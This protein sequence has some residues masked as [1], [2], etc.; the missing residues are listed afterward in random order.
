LADMAHNFP[1]VEGLR[2]AQ[3][4]FESVK[5][6]EDVERLFLKGA[7]LSPNT[8]RPYLQA[9]KQ[10]YQFTNGLNPLQVRPSDIEAFYD[11]QVKRIDRNT[12]Y[13][14]IRVPHDHG[15]PHCEPAETREIVRQKRESRRRLVVLC[16]HPH[17]PACALH[18]GH[19]L[20]DKGSIPS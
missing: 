8:Y 16:N 18:S 20:Q 17:R 19:K 6:F 12:A 4:V 5:S 3:S 2:K 15:M 11:A 14:R 7:G 13:L 9:V 10:F 1:T